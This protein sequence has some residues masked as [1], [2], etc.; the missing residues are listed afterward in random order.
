MSV[1]AYKY[2]RSFFSAIFYPSLVKIIEDI[3]DDTVIRVFVLVKILGVW[4]DSYLDKRTK[5]A[6]LEE[7]L[8]LK[9][10]T[11]E[12]SYPVFSVCAEAD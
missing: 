6:Y 4:I 7:L 3:I 8:L 11:A 2:L 1:Y 10:K 5:C 12:G 9:D